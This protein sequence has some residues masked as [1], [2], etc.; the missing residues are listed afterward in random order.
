MY[1]YYLYLIFFERCTL[2][3]AVAG[4]TSRLDNIQLKSELV[5]WKI[6]KDMINGKVSLKDEYKFKSVAERDDS[7]I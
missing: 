1:N 2:S 5:N 3:N 4:L 7:N 6:D